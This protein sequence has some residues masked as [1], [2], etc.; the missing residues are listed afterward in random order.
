MTGSPAIFIEGFQVSKEMFGIIFA[1]LA[2]AMIGGGQVNNFLLRRWTS[3]VIFQCGLIGQVI[4]SA[5]F[6]ITLSTMSLS[7]LPTIIFFFVILACIGTA[8]PNS[9]AL[10]LK[11]LSKNIGSG[12]ALMGFLQMGVG[13]GLASLVGVF[14]VK[15]SL[16]TAVVILISSI[17]AGIVLWTG[18]GWKKI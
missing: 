5:L 10:A 15:G 14:D 1:A 16:P 13:A 4:L 9:T 18:S 3:E 6:L 8:F 17:L 12:S 7:L 11:P 2:V